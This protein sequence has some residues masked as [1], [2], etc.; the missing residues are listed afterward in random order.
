MSRMMKGGLELEPPER[1]IGLAAHDFMMAMGHERIVLTR[2]ARR[3]TRRP[4]PRAGCSGCSPSPAR[5]GRARCAARGDE[6]IAWARSL[7]AGAPRQVRAAP[8]AGAAAR[9]AAEEILGDRDRDAAARSLCGLCAPH[10]GADAARPAAARSRR[11]RAR[12]AVPRRS[13]SRFTESCPDPSACRTP[14]ALLIAAGRAAFAEAALP[15]DIEAVWWP[16]FGAS[17]DAH[18]GLGA[19]RARRGAAAAAPRCA[20]SRIA[21]GD[22][23]VDAVRLCRP[24]RPACRPGTADIL[25]Y[26]TGSS[27]SKAQAH[28]LLA[29]QLALEGALLMRGAFKAIGPLQPGQL[30]YVRLKANG[31]VDEES[32]LEYGKTMRTRRRAFR[33]RLAAAGRA[34]APLRRSRRRAICRAPCRS[35]KARPTATTTIWPACSNGRRAAT[36]SRAKPNEGAAADPAGDARRARRSPPIPGNSVWVSANAGSGKTHVLSRRVI[37]LLLQGTDPSKILCLTYTRA[38]AANMAKRVYDDLAGWTALAD[39]E[40]AERDRAARRPRRRTPTSCAG[41]AGCSPRRWRRR[42]G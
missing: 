23:G 10:P 37:R 13:C 41:R 34:A 2:S 14:Q 12:H 25:D 36:T 40:L 42:A 21:I 26:K 32:I 15:A 9:R 38:A 28:T 6:L 4:P 39:D 35:A 17:V 24:H 22:T 1:R 18:P 16:R 30:A 27:P 11:C 5:A 20:P 29:P 19:A 31:E 7:D 33:R 3:A 8:E